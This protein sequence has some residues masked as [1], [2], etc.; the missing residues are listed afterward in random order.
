[1]ISF[2][3][4]LASQ[5]DDALNGAGSTT[6][7]ARAG[8]KIVVRS[9][10]VLG[11]ANATNVTFNSKGAGVGTPISPLLANGANGGFALPAGSWFETAVGEGLTVTTGAGST[12]GIWIAW[13]YV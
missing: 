13:D 8:M 12:A 5:T 6:P 2:K 10:F 11:G 3:N 1:M 9:V 7:A 4:V